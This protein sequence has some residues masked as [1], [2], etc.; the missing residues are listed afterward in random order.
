MPL[1]R[2]GQGFLG[3]CNARAVGGLVRPFR[4]GYDRNQGLG[5]SDIPDRLDPFNYE[6]VDTLGVRLQKLSGN[7]Y[8]CQDIV[9]AG[10][11]VN[12]LHLGELEQ[13]VSDLR[14]LAQD[15]GHIDEGTN[16]PFHLTVRMIMSG[17]QVLDVLATDL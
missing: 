4:S 10:N 15:R 7:L 2:I 5:I 3:P 8:D 9:P 1:T 6:P 12:L 13:S 11:D 17:Y 16:M 14:L